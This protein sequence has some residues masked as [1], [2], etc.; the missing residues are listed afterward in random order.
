MW[1]TL[2]ALARSRRALRRLLST[3]VVLSTDAWTTAIEVSPL[4]ESL[5][6]LELVPQLAS[7]AQTHFSGAEDQVVPVRTLRRFTEAQPAARVEVIDAF[8]HDCCWVHAWEQLRQ[9]T[10]VATL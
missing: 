4:A 7:I 8:D 6:P 3:F 2:F 5:N 9:R 1:K 10:C